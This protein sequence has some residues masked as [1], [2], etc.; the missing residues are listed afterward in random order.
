MKIE[1]GTSGW[2]ALISEDFTFD[3]VRL[4]SQAL[5][6]YLKKTKKT[7][8]GI[9]VAHDVRFL[10]ED[11]AK[12]AANVI[13]SNDI[14]VYFPDRPTPTPVVSFSI[15]DK[16]LQGGIIISASHNPPEYNGFKFS[17][18]YGGPSPK[19]VTKQ[20]EQEVSKL[21]LK[22]IKIDE[23]KAEEK[24][25]SFNPVSA[26]L[27]QL[28]K[29]LN[30]K[31]MKR[32]KIKIALDCMTGI[33]TGYLDRFLQQLGYKLEVINQEED[34]LFAGRAPDPRPDNLKELITKV[35]TGG[36]NLG[37]SVDGD[38]DR[39]GVVD[40]D[41]DFVYPNQV[42]SLVFYY[43][44]NARKKR[45][46]VARSISTTHLVDEIAKDY[47]LEVVETPVG[48][49]YIGELL[50]TG[51][52]IM[53]G[54]ESGGLSIGG[55]LPEKDGMLAD[56]LVVEALAYFRKPLKDI[57]KEI[58]KK[59]GKFYNKRI[60]FEIEKSQQKK[61]MDKLSKN[62]PKEI[63]QRKVVEINKWDGYKFVLD[64]GDWLMFRASGTE[65]AIRCY[66]ES[67]TKIGFKKIEDEAMKMMNLSSVLV[68]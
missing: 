51:E 40:G 11:F 16:K 43:L 54:E 62:P 28:E 65:A 20:I 67:R 57:L 15:K 17:S 47:G 5:A 66:L 12:A 9:I 8:N 6:N 3:N 42:I 37:L 1:F 22:S 10:S 44:V 7:K 36:F 61:F 39:F 19:E 32:H 13:A 41:G 23:K 48:F 4:L 49:K 27:R 50:D 60:N 55:H 26:Y 30:V 18:E 59:Y 38:A 45:P 33:V 14:S 52:Y 21:S 35:R 29:V 56:L 68:S 63:A 25:R 58:Y 24:I 64:N 2:R 53:G 34:C 46:K 31:M